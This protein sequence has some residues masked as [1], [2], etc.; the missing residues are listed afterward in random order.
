MGQDVAAYE[1]TKFR[2]IETPVCVLGL[3]APF[4]SKRDLSNTAFGIRAVEDTPAP[5]HDRGFTDLQTTAGYFRAPQVS[6]DAY[7][8]AVELSPRFSV[9]PKG[10]WTPAGNCTS[11][12]LEH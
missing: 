7:L 1:N 4:T 11:T 6:V 2:C 10:V 12:T 3:F 8:W 5:R 9:S